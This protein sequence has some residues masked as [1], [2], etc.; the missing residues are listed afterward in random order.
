M[1]DTDSNI[2]GCIIYRAGTM[3]LDGVDAVRTAVCPMWNEISIDDIY[4]DS[5]S[6]V[7][8]YTMHSLI[9]S[10]LIEQPNAYSRVDLKVS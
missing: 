1:P 5:A 9:G 3:G 6:G 8:H 2:A 7:H 4:S 10:V